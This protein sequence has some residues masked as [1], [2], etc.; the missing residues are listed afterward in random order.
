MSEPAV[1]NRTPTL[2]PQHVWNPSTAYGEEKG[3][4]HSCMNTATCRWR[5]PEL[6]P[7]RAE[8]TGAGAEGADLSETEVVYSIR[9]IFQSKTASR[10]E[11]TDLR[12]MNHA[13]TKEMED[14]H[15]TVTDLENLLGKE[16]WEKEKEL[17]AFPL[18]VPS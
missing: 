11:K 14:F 18:T 3:D 10:K 5:V 15:K 12:T 17:H 16:K 13:V 7:S 2:S 1:K 9:D 8:D 4:G 6:D